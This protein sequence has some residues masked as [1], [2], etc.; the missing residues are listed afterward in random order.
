L[1]ALDSTLAAPWRHLLRASGPQ[2][3]SP[4]RPSGCHGRTVPSRRHAGPPRT[5]RWPGASTGTLRREADDAEPP[6]RQ[7]GQR[8]DNGARRSGPASAPCAAPGRRS[9]PGEHPG[10]YPGQLTEPSPAPGTGSARWHS[11]EQW[12]ESQHRLGNGWLTSW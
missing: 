3:A 7:P 5:G 12:E 4:L 11:R 1:K 10:Q 9:R 2:L 8:N 6:Q